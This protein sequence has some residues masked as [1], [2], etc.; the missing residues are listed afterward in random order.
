M[1]PRSEVNT[2]AQVYCKSHLPVSAGMAES[3]VTAGER[4]TGAAETKRRPIGTT[5]SR[6]LV[7]AAHERRG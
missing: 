3:Q 2:S 6:S 4:T 5:R 1:L 7:A